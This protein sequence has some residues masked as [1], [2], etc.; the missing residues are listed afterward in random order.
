MPGDSDGTAR[1]A[2]NHRNLGLVRGA[3]H[4][5]LVVNIHA[6]SSNIAIFIL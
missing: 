4:F 6:I 2:S 5:H 3:T 1:V